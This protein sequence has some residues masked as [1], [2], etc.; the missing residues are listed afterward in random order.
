MKRVLYHVSNITNL[1]FVN[2]A[3]WV[4]NVEQLSLHQHRTKGL[5]DL[6]HTN[7]WGLS[8]VVSIEGARYYVTS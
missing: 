1:I 6:I 2:F 3:S 5:L 4:G 7:V 8:L